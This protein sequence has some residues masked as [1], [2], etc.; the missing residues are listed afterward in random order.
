MKIESDDVARFLRDNPAFFEQHV[1]L[2]TEINLPHLYDEKTV[3][4]T[5]Y[6]VSALREKN[7]TLETKLRELIQFGEENDALGDRV[8]RFSLA[9]LR[10]GSR[11]ALLEAVYYQLR[12]DFAVPHVGIRLWSGGPGERA[13]FAPTSQELRVY[14]ESLSHPSC[15]THALYETGTWFGAASEHLKS[16]ALVALRGDQ[17]FG[18][19]VLASEDPQRFYQGMGTLYLKRLGELLSAALSHH[20]GGPG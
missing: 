8:H 10:A 17:T 2:L 16:F 5:E 4:L 3:S 19:M 6:Q 13:E 11:D 7:A 1:G 9:L 12:E 14:A 20:L 18:L 15:G